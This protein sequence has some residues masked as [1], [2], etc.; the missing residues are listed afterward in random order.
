MSFFSR[1]K[2]MNS[3]MYFISDLDEEKDLK[4]DDMDFK[5][6]TVL[7]I[8]D[9]L[10]FIIFLILFN[11]IVLCNGRCRKYA[12]VDSWKLQELMAQSGLV[13]NLN[14]IKSITDLPNPIYNSNSVLI[15]GKYKVRVNKTKNVVIVYEKGDDGKYQKSVKVMSAI[16]GRDIRVN[17]EYNIGDRWLWIKNQNGNYSKFVTQVSGNVVFESIAYK[18]KGDLSSLNYVEFDNLGNSI[19]GSFI[20][21]QYADAQWIFDNL[22]YDTIVEFYESEDLNGVNVPEV[23][24]I[25]LEN[26]KKNWDPTYTGSES[27]W[28]KVKNDGKKK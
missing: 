17:T 2:N 3:S 1:N 6:R 15:K 26:D 27:P 7:I 14:E 11:N 16:V 25:S 4:N 24:K 12:K 18:K 8:L 22:D 9:V 23:K 21:L 5:I 28:N 10:A 19:D 20:K 13:Q